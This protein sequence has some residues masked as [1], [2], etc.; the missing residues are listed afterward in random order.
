MCFLNILSRFCETD[1]SRLSKHITERNMSR[2]CHDVYVRAGAQ[3]YHNAQEM[4]PVW[5]SKSVAQLASAY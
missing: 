2:V 4:S 1:C 3:H 5:S